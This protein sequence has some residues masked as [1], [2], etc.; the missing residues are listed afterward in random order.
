MAAPIQ[1]EAK[2]LASVKFY[3]FKLKLNTP[4]EWPTIVT[5]VAL[6]AMIAVWTAERICIAVLETPFKSVENLGSKAVSGFGLL[7]LFIRETTVGFDRG[8]EAGEESGV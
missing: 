7:G 8:T 1:D 5:P 6:W 2:I 3:K 4:R